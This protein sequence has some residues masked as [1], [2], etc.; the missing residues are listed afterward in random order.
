[1][2]ASRLDKLIKIAAAGAVL[3]FG[4]C[5]VSA[6]VRAEEQAAFETKAKSAVL[7]DADENLV[8]FE[9]VPDIV[10]PPASMSKLM[11]LAIVFREPRQTGEYGYREEVQATHTLL[12]TLAPSLAVLLADLRLA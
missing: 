5:A 4:A 9:K 1:M 7:L 8:L 3:V 2:Y 6:T 10:A 12:P 11:T